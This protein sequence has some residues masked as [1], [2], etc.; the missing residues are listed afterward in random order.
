MTDQ[1]DEDVQR[2]LAKWPDVPHCFGW[3][4]LDRRGMWR[5]KDAPITHARAR[6]FLARNYAADEAGRYFVQN[7][8]QRAYCDLEYT[9]WI[10]HVDGADDLYT[11]TAAKVAQISALLVDEEGDL[12]LE[13]ELGIG[14][15]IDRDLT[16]FVERLE[17]DAPKSDKTQD[18]ASRLMGLHAT[19]AAPFTLRWQGFDIIASAV[20]KCDIASRYGYAPQPRDQP[21]A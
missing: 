14:L 2:A 12:L 8:P 11:H 10:L 18:L 17:H 16:R 4:G 20:R 6:E 19:Q 1:F 3:L 7:G 13:T 21:E 5:I 15:L 9:P